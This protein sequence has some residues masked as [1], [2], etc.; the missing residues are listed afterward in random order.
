MERDLRI[1]ISPIMAFLLYIHRL[2]RS[3][4]HDDISVVSRVV[5]T[6]EYHEGLTESSSRDHDNLTNTNGES[7]YSQ[8]V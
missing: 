6:S 5:E 2:R 1:Y 7:I 3:T 4:L 8:L